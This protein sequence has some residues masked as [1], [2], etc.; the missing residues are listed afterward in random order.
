MGHLA[1][2][3]L[4]MG[5]L[6]MVGHLVM[7]SLVM[8]CLVMVGSFFI[9]KTVIQGNEFPIDQNISGLLSIK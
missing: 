2:G 6:V 4:V 7:G 3:S 5:C 8:V 1:M 9:I